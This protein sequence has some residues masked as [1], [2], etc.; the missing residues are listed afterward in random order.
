MDGRQCDSLSL[1]GATYMHAHLLPDRAI[2]LAETYVGS[3]FPWSRGTVSVGLGRYTVAGQRAVQ[4]SVSS[5]TV[6]LFAGS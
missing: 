5:F 1:D 2:F 3:H 6:C 4:C